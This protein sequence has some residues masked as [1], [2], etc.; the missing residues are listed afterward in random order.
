MDRK[1]VKSFYGRDLPPA[2]IRLPGQVEIRPDRV[3]DRY[4]CLTYC[5]VRHTDYPW[6]SKTKKSASASS[7]S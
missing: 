6:I 3:H 2:N 1:T 5:I 4:F 7:A